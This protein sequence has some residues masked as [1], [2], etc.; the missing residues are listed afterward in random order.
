MDHSFDWQKKTLRRVRPNWNLFLIWLLC[1]GCISVGVITTPYLS[2]ISLL[3]FFITML[4]ARPDDTF[5]LLFGLLPFANIFKLSTTSMSLFT[6]CETGLAVYLL[7]KNRIRVS[8]FF[9]LTLLVL[10]LLFFSLSNL[11]LLTIVKTIVGL[12]LIGFAASVLT[13]EGLKSAARLLSLSTIVMLLLSRNRAYLSYVEK[14]YG[15]L[16]YYVDAAGRATNTLRISGFLG[17]PNYCAVLLVMVLALL[18]VLYYHKAIRAEFWLYSA[19]LVPFGFLTYSKTY[20]L[21][22]A[23]LL[24]MLILF[25]LFPKHKFWALL[26]LI[27]GGVVVWL[28]VNRKIEA[29]N[30]ILAR[31]SG[32]D[33]TT[34]RMKLNRDYLQ[35]IFEHAKVLFF[36]DGI[37]ADRFSG[38]GNNVHCLYIELLYKLGVVGTFLYCGTLS[39]ALS[40]PRKQLHRPFANYLPLAFFLV[41][42]AFLAALVNYALPFYI[43]IVAAAYNYTDSDTE[44]EDAV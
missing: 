34:G 40:Q 13:K 27:G 39:A 20:F 33:F 6:I 9:M 29:I 38:A 26:S 31:F 19:F 4:A 37:S 22:I 3:L 14:Y 16:D 15:D 11:S 8:Q 5:A 35:Y 43:I 18:C 21:C 41:I 7:L 2:I 36:G 32:G 23:I 28:A 24:V 17:D 10:Y 42:F 44:E 1:L 12:L 25:V 30:M